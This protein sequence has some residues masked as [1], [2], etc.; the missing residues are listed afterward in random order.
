MLISDLTKSEAMDK[1]IS[2][3]MEN[4]NIKKDT[5]IQFVEDDEQWDDIVVGY[6]GKNASFDYVAE[7]FRSVLKDLI[8]L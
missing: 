4:E 2:Y 5:V 6:Y 3:I 7:A 1:I 8:L